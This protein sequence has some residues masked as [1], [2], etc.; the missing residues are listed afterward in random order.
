MVLKSKL[1]EMMVH[2]ASQIYRKYITMDRKKT[3]VLYLKMQKAL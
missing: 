2:I 3:P 1:A